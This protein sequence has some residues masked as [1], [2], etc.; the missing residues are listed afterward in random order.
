MLRCTNPTG[1][2]T[3]HGFQR[4]KTARSKSHRMGRPYRKAETHRDERRLSLLYSTM[5]LSIVESSAGTGSS[6]RT[7]LKPPHDP[8]LCVGPADGHWLL[9]LRVCK[10]SEPAE[11][12]FDWSVTTIHSSIW[13][14][15]ETQRPVR[16]PPIACNAGRKSKRAESSSQFDSVLSLFWK[17]CALGRVQSSHVVRSTRRLWLCTP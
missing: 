14:G 10:V 3:K 2:V 7:P 6:G 4:P 8:T 1:R 17:V 13:I 9:H 16:T 15:R 12:T 5:V 11:K